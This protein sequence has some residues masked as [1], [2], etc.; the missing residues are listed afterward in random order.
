MDC[1]PTFPAGEFEAE[2]SLHEIANIPASQ[3]LDLA[4]KDS[5]PS[6]YDENGGGGGDDDDDKNNTDKRENSGE[7]ATSTSISSGVSSKVG[8]K[9]KPEGDLFNTITP[10]LLFLS[11]AFICA[12][13]SDS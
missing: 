12:A 8:A 13:I 5:K 6:N 10:T 4:D 2:V 11:L 9:S 7:E 3:G 1:L